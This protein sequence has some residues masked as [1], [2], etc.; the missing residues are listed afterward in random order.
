MQKILVLLGCLGCFLTACDGRKQDDKAAE[1][2]K[3][4]VQSEVAVDVADVSGNLWEE[5][6]GEPEKFHAVYEKLTDAQKYYFCAAFSIGAL[7]VSKPETASLMV[8][9]FMGL[10]V[11]QYPEGINAENYQ[12][13]NFG[14]NIFRYELVVNDILDNNMCEEVI[15]TADTFAK[16]KHYSSEELSEKGGPEVEKIVNMMKQVQQ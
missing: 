4:V 8:D 11:V 16:D 6:S 7:S 2:E 9:Y 10:G 14:K 13:F 3:S 5:I 12:A 1:P 15:I